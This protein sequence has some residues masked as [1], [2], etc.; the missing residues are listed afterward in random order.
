MTNI[1]SE[2]S[3]THPNSS[4]T[5]KKA[6]AS[7]LKRPVTEE[8]KNHWLKRRRPAIQQPASQLE[9]E[10]ASLAMLKQEVFEGEKTHRERKQE[11]EEIL[12]ELEKNKLELDIKIR[13]LQLKKLQEQHVFDI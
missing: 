4:E 13:Q 1:E 5:W 6:T 10:Y 8:L 11:R 2:H 3:Y 9:D 12:F 7:D